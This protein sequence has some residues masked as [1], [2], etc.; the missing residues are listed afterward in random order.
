MHRRLK[1]V[2]LLTAV[3]LAAVVG[4]VA[5][6]AGVAHGLAISGAGGNPPAGPFQPYGLYRPGGFGLFGP[7]LFVLFSF[8]LLR[9]L[10][11]GGFHRRRWMYSGLTGAPSRFEEWHRR[12]HER[13]NTPPS[14]QPK[15]GA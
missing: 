4:F 14:A 5:Y 8:F 6:N 10:F 15:S 12:A 13:M 7:L 2:I 1:L 11:W 3:L 9:V